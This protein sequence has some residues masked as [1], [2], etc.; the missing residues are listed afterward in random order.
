MR[1]HQGHDPGSPA[2]PCL[3]YSPS[4]WLS[5]KLS[6][7]QVYEKIVY[8]DIPTTFPKLLSGAV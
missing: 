1:S 2:T 8:E 6:D 4:S 7:L 5:S 3:V